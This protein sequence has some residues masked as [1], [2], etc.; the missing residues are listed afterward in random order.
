MAQRTFFRQISQIGNSDNYLDTLTMANAETASVNIEDDLNFLRTGRKEVVGQTNWFDAPLDNFNLTAIHDKLFTYAIQKTD[1]VVVGATDNFVLLAGATKPVDVISFT[2][3]TQGAIC[4]QLAGA[5]GANDLTVSGGNGNLIPIRDA[6]TNDPIFT[7]T[8]QI[9]GLLQVGSLATNGNAF[10]DTGNDQAQLSFVYINPATEA[11]T[12]CPAV[13]I[14]GKTIEYGYRKRVDFFNL[15]ENA[16]DGT[17]NFVENVALGTIDIQDAYNNSASG[18]ILLSAGKNLTVDLNALADF[19]I[20]DGVNSFLLADQSLATLRANVPVEMLN[21]NELRYYDAG[22]SNYVGFS[23]PA[24]TANTSYVL[25]STDATVAGQVL[26]SNAAGVLSWVGNTQ[27]GGK[28]SRILTANIAADTAIDISTFVNPDGIGFGANGA[29]FV[30]N[31]SVFL[32]G[33]MLLHGADATANNDVYWLSATQIAFEF[34]LF[35]VGNR[36]DIIQVIQHK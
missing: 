13:D 27:T 3:G 28:A 15:P 7:G 2:A 9:Y 35:G 22:S 29:D 26:S 5:I 31:F 24:L 23:S 20:T 18:N 10:G 6:V 25:P 16:F 4:A 34:D 21:G 14:Q 19:E 30:N 12:A 36:K 33:N 1:D 8:E 11:I 32:N 17:L